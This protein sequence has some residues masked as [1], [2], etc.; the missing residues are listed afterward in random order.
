MLKKTLATTIGAATLIGSGFA[1]A[2]DTAHPVNNES[3]SVYH[4]AEYG[5][6]DG[7]LARVDT[8]NMQAGTGTGTN[9]IDN[10]EQV[11]GDSGWQ[12][13]QHRYDFV[14]GRLVHTDTISHDTPRPKV[15]ADT[16]TLFADGH[17]VGSP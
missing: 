15:A 3:G 2:T 16:N 10:W 13:R 12:L 11:P 5:K 1:L 4:G 7:R 14:N 8:W 6:V 17:F 9:A